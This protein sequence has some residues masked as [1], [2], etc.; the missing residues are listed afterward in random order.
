M[1]AISR[2]DLA[3]S[4]ASC[5]TPSL[6]IIVSCSML[7]QSLCVSH[8]K[9]RETID[10]TGQRILSLRTGRCPPSSVHP[11]VIIMEN[12]HC[13]NSV[14]VVTTYTDCIRR[15]PDS[16]SPVPTPSVSGQSRVPRSEPRHAGPARRQRPRIHEQ[17]NAKV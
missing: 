13:H 9:K 12:V 14:N 7:L 16:P 17:K 1:I 2:S 3:I 15:I 6:I 4:H 10:M 8:F 11:K 5:I